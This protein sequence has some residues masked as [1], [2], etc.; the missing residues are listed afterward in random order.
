ML[1]AYLQVYINR[2]TQSSKVCEP[3]QKIVLIVAAYKG[4]P[5]ESIPSL[6]RWWSTPRS[7]LGVR[8]NYIRSGQGYVRLV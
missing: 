7:K 6:L 2:D 3:I 8:L 5:E 4:T 1:N